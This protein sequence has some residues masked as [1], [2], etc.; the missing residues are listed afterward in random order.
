MSELPPG[1]G[2]ILRGALIRRYGDDVSSPEA[3]QVLQAVQDRDMGVIS[4][5]MEEGEAGYPNV[6]ALGAGQLGLAAT[7]LSRL[8]PLARL[9]PKI[10]AGMAVAGKLADWGLGAYGAA[11]L[12]D[13][14][15]REQ[16]GLPGTGAQAAW[17]A[18]DLAFP[19]VGAGGALA[20]RIGT[21][22]ASKFP[23]LRKAILGGDTSLD[24][25]KGGL[26]RLLTGGEFKPK[27]DF[28]SAG[29]G[30]QGAADAGAAA[31][32]EREFAERVA[33]MAPDEAEQ[34]RIQRERFPTDPRFDAPP[35]KSD[36]SVVRDASEGRTDPG[37]GW[38]E[39]GVQATRRA[40]GTT[41]S[42]L[43]PGP[44]T[45]AQ[46]GLPFDKPDPM[47][48]DVRFSGSPE[49]FEKGATPFGP[50]YP[51]AGRTR[52]PGEDALTGQQADAATV[53]DL[54]SEDIYDLEP[55]VVVSKFEDAIQ[56]LGRNEDLGLEAGT[57][58]ELQ[59]IWT[60]AGAR[61]SKIADDIE[62]LRAQA[63]E[64]YAKHGEEGIAQ[65]QNLFDIYNGIMG[66]G[67]EVEQ[68]SARLD[69]AEKAVHNAL[70]GT[71]VR[72]RKGM[73]TGIEGA[74]S[75][76]I[77][78][79]TMDNLFSGVKYTA[80]VPPAP[81]PNMRPGYSVPLTPTTKKVPKVGRRR[82]PSNQQNL[83]GPEVP[84]EGTDFQASQAVKRKER[85]TPQPKV[86]RR[87]GP[88]P[89][90]FVIQGLT[91]ASG[92]TKRVGDYSEGE[93]NQILERLRARVE[94]TRIAGAQALG[95]GG[96][97]GNIDVLQ[98]VINN[99]EQA[100]NRRSLGMSSRVS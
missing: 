65:D 73:K 78:R 86:S 10:G 43:Q 28:T 55:S 35:P 94:Q 18:A 33:K 13:A 46:P 83:F 52:L 38:D 56:A 51:T 8:L 2:E 54:F 90:E 97:A 84:L 32:R 61:A 25:E 81:P 75:Q 45:D 41:P 72:V 74:E 69:R 100:L 70:K 98:D 53:T 82:Q 26:F 68:A 79:E 50:R 42:P 36:A 29:R 7:S 31:K 62:D 58:N 48:A 37:R 99:I 15:K 66:Q 17:G 1:M 89:E 92:S 67:G 19:A 93:L 9:H 4:T 71:V 88:D 44:G 95:G 22:R 16:L 30:F 5:L 39:R 57:V 60:T 85:G 6:G 34:L 40:T 27:A 91:D 87:Q 23:K 11:N 24:A 47:Q 63:A 59:N 12:H 14:Y 3:Q 80:P 77:A 96:A 64:L 21:S 20:R 76:K 49:S